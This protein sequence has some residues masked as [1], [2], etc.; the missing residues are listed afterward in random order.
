M[1]TKKAAAKAAPAKKAAA[2][3]APAKAAKGSK[4]IGKPEVI[5][6][7]SPSRGGAD[8]VMS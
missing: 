4:G 8:I 7:G 5:D 1:A 6:K 2:K 3:K